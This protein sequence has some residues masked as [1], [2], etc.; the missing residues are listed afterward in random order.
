MYQSTSLHLCYKHSSEVVLCNCEGC[1]S[2]LIYASGRL[3]IFNCKLTLGSVTGIYQ[4]KQL[5][6]FSVNTSSTLLSI[7][8]NLLKCTPT[9]IAFIDVY[10]KTETRAIR[11]SRVSSRHTLTLRLLLV[12]LLTRQGLLVELRD[13]I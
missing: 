3:S 5:L 9:H 11:K 12:G 8:V 1:L 10:L 7:C 13:S 6:H 4:R 2:N